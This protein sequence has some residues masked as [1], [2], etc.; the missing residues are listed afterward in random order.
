MSIYDALLAQAH[1]VSLEP[2]ETSYFS[3]SGAGLDPRLFR[4][5]KLI[6]TVRSSIMR[7]LLDHLKTNYANP[8]AYAHIWLAGSAVSYQWTAARNP[9][10]LDCLIG[11]NYLSFRQN[12]Q[13]YK[14]LSDKQ[15]ATML[16]EDFR[17]IQEDLDNFMG[18][19]ELTFYVNV[20]SDI[21][22]IKPYAAYSLTNDE[23]TVAP[24][25]KAAPV[26]KM[27]ERKVGTDT[28]LTT[29]ILARYSKAFNDIHA[30]TTD[31]ARRNAEAALKLAIDQG[32]ALFD[33]IHQGR[34]YAFSPSGLG[35]SDI[36]NYRWQAGKSAG[37]IQALRKLK[38]IGKASKKEYEAKTYGMEL[39]DA[40]TL[41]RRALG[42]RK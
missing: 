31:T 42:A 2:S 23:W 20:N 33:D 13:Q 14:S 16:N 41:I 37:T 22:T 3:P 30:A 32:T 25:I 1:P 39:P 12:N 5:N 28:S 36:H 24:E 4:N 18:A 27:W 21:R 7:I 9:A 6:P 29:D 34:K 38:D 35:Y 26:N 19:Y 17:D 10:D 40:N 8:E 15:I 11:I